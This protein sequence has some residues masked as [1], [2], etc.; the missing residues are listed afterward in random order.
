MWLL[1]NEPRG[2]LVG[3]EVRKVKGVELQTVLNF[4]LFKIHL[5][6][7]RNRN[8]ICL[9]MNLRLKTLMFIFL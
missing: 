1:Q 9:K 8:L 3:D 5:R 2:R 4:V 6:M 7:L